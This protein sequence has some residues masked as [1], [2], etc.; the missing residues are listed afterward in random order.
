MA[1]TNV[2]KP[3]ADDLKKHVME[4]FKDA[5]KDC[6]NQ[7][8]K[9]EFRRLG[10]SYDCLNKCASDMFNFLAEMGHLDTVIELFKPCS[11]ILSEV[12]VFTMVI[13]LYSSTRKANTVLK[14]YRKMLANGVEPVSYTYTTLICVLASDFSKAVYL[15]LAKKYFLET[16]G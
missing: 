2:P 7:M 6:E 11:G 10:S 13:T 12:A 15:R 4:V 16:F 3:S 5:T 9:A 8:L 14:V 1:G